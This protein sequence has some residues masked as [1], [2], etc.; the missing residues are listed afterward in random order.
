MPERRSKRFPVN[1]SARIVCNGRSYEGIVGN[2]SEEGLSYIITTFI[3]ADKE[4]VP[5]GVFEVIIN[6][7]NR[8][9]LRLKCEVRWFLKP[10]TGGKSL[11]TGMHIAEPSLKYI[12]WIEEVKARH[13]K[14][15]NPG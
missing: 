11:I 1:I 2:V 7:P 14:M 5:K 4:F 8:E 6:V 15:M 9:E 12:E 13:Q 3:Q 10:S